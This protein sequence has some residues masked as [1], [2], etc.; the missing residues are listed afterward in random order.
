MCEHIYCKRE[1]INFQLF[2]YRSTKCLFSQFERT[3]NLCMNISNSS[4]Y[5]LGVYE[6][7]GEGDH[8]NHPSKPFSHWDLKESIHP[9]Q[10]KVLSLSHDHGTSD[11]FYAMH[12]W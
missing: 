8:Q 12:T 3:C 10:H 11:V 4:L 5:W 6:F 9:S 1:L 7:S 2:S